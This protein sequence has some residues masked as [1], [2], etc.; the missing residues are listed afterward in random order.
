LILNRLHTREKLI[1][2]LHGL[3]FHG[4]KEAPKLILVREADSS[5]VTTQEI[6][7]IIS[8]VIATKSILNGRHSRVV[9]PS[10]DLVIFAILVFK[11][12]RE[13]CF[14]FI[15]RMNMRLDITCDITPSKMAFEEAA[16]VL[17]PQNIVVPIKNSDNSLGKLCVIH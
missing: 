7:N 4:D 12:I 14:V 5:I 13:I 6:P 15:L 3:L 2:R 1:D 17:D 11:T 9:E 16:Y 10:D 8:V